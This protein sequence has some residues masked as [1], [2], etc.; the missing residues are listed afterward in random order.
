[1]VSDI[2]E[3]K[4]SK[5]FAMAELAVVSSNTV[6]TEGLKTGGALTPGSAIIDAHE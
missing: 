4:H 5:F 2:S 3:K 6:D 1:M